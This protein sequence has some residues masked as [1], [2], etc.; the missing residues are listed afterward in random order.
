MT[1]VTRS[2]LLGP[3]QRL[4]PPTIRR[5][6][7]TA[8][9]PREPRFAMAAPRLL[10]RMRA[11]LRTRHYSIR[12]EEA[13]VQWA[14]RFILFE[15]KKHPS[16]MGAPEI[17]EFLTHLAVERNVSASTQTQALA[18]ILFL[19]PSSVSGAQATSRGRARSAR[20]RCGRR[21]RESVDA[22]CA[23][24]EV[25][26]RQCLVVVAVGLSGGAAQHRPAKRSGAA[27]SPRRV[28]H[29]ASRTRGRAPG[30]HRQSGHAAHT[31]TLLR[32]TRS[33]VG[34]RHSDRAEAP[35]TLRRQDD[36]DLHARPGDGR[37]RVRSPLDAL[38]SATE[39]SP[40]H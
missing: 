24:G 22:G 20:S 6:L 36:D 28:G 19:Y 13:Y 27:T 4:P 38:G 26:E 7:D 32:H 34:S 12:T 23:R 2:A 29:P 39:D 35:G 21:I 17:N 11:R 1:G 25:P 15:G 10:D 16:A 30:R 5:I 40:S 33:G 37:V 14:K 3:T 8:S 9:A 31:A 18:A